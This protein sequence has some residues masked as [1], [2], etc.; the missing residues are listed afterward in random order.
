MSNNGSN[1]DNSATV[2]G[3]IQG[4]A[5]PQEIVIKMDCGGYPSDEAPL[6]KQNENPERWEVRPTQNGRSTRLPEHSD[7]DALRDAFRRRYD[8]GLNGHERGLLRDTLQGPSTRIP[9]LPATGAEAVEMITSL[10][11]GVYGAASLGGQFTAYMPNYHHLRPTWA[12]GGNAPSN[13]WP[14]EPGHAPVGVH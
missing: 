2:P 11:R 14:V 1:P 9:R 6:W 5:V 10:G 13:I 12:G 8:N 4:P 7:T 3:N